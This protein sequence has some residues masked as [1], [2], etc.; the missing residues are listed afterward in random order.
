MSI[1]TSWD[2]RASSRRQSPRSPGGVALIDPG[3]ST[4]LETLRTALDEQGIAVA[5][6]RAVLLTHIHLD[7][8]GAVGSLVKENRQIEVYVH[9]RGA[10]HM[11]DPAKL[12]VSATPTV[13]SRHGPSLG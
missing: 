7:H 10:P 13:W 6:I 8:A 3:P 1:S 5:D 11:I 2:V 9:E 12:L 4:C